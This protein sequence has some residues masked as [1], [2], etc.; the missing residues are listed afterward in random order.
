MSDRFQPPRDPACDTESAIRRLGG[1]TDLFR[2]L[3][4]ALVNDTAGHLSRL[5]AAVAASDAASVHQ[6]AHSLRGL[7]ATCGA[8]G[9]AQA[10][11]ELEELGRS[12]GLDLEQATARL[13]DIERG[14]EKVRQGLA[15]YLRD[16]PL[17]G[18]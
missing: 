2:D 14:L 1:A 17:E 5:R 4:R 8:D 18:S 15:H 9:V 6:A 13:L 7:A 11:G 16:G 12:S 10:A 3:L